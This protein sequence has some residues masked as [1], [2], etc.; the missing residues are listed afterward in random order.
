MRP[1]MGAVAVAAAMLVAPSA[2]FAGEEDPALMQFK[3]PSSADY[4]DFES[5]GLNMDHAVENA[6]DGG[7]LVSAWVTDEEKA[8]AEARGYSAVK[9]VHDKNN[10]DRIRAEREE[11]IADE[12]AANLALKVNAEGVKGK[13][14]VPG[15]VRAQR[16]D[17]YENNVGRFISIEAN[18]TEAQ[19]TCTG[20]TA[21]SAATP[22]RC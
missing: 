21:R 2:V 19:I 17:F 3:L 12:K 8:L 6:A 18:T 22:A 20:P 14:A 16:A 5:M 7:V 15:T 13:S 11:S 10:I 4:E 1:W 9:T